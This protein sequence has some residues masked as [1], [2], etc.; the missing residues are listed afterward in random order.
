MMAK[1]NWKGSMQTVSL[2][3]WT[4]WCFNV[5]C[6]AI[7]PL[8]WWILQTIWRLDRACTIASFVWRFHC[9]HVI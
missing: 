6:I 7:I 2:L 9:I 3:N 5:W 8:P 1:P 4:L